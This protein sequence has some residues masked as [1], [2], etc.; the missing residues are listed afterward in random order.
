MQISLQEFDQIILTW[1]QFKLQH[2][3]YTVR[4]KKKSEQDNRQS[5]ACMT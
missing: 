1:I 2:I 4:V 5:N 3:L